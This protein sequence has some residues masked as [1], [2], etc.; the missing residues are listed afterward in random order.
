[1]KNKI[2]LINTA[3]KIKY[4]RTKVLKLSQEA[5]A[6]KIGV[7]RNTVKNW[8]NDISKPTVSHLLMISI[9]CDVSLNYLISDNSP[10]ELLLYNLDDDIYKIIKLL[11]DYYKKH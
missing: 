1:M 2:D 11:I 7:T 3:D 9:I 10:E 4:L 8:E 6:A 5:F